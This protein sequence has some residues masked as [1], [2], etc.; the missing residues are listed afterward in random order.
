MLNASNS[1]ERP[2]STTAGR[3]SRMRRLADTLAGTLS[4]QVAGKSCV[5]SD[6]R[7]V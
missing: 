3:Q 6:T 1:G 4:T 2:D 7:Q 5:R